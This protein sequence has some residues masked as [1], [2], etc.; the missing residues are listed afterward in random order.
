MRPPPNEAPEEDLPPPKPPE[1]APPR[2]AG[3]AD[4]R[5]E[6]GVAVRFAGMFTRA[7][8]IRLPFVPFTTL[9]GAPFEERIV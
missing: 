8:A 6:G 2:G 7:V 4:M 9:V 1:A 3:G 5:A